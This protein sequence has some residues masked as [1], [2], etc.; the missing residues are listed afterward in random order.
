[1]RT[2]VADR[3]LDERGS[4]HNLSVISLNP[5]RP[6]HNAETVVIARMNRKPLHVAQVVALVECCK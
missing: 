4:S 1:M 6:T 3:D 5:T 2:F